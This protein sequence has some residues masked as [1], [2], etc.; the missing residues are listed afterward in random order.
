MGPAGNT[1]G[2]TVGIE[3][4]QLESEG[5]GDQTSVVASGQITERLS[6]RYGVGIFE[7]GTTLGLR[8]KLT[9]RLYLDAASG[10][11]NSL[12]LF[13]RRSF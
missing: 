10:L 2:P 4:F 9:R 7:P 3:D 8:Y 5:S 1:K 12:D 11:A 6:L 13:Y